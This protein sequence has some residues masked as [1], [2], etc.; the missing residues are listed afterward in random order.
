LCSLVMLTCP[1]HM[2]CSHVMLT[3]HAHMSFSHFMLT[4]HAYMSCSR[5]MF[6][7]HSHMSCLHVMLTFAT[8]ICCSQRLTSQFSPFNPFANGQLPFV[9]LSANGLAT[10][11]RLHDDQMVNRLRKIA[12]V[13]IFP[14]SV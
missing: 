13:S 14:F 11:F 4:C 1:A 9:S 10:N 8:R 3:C 6:T 5:V 12:W 7:C 2:L